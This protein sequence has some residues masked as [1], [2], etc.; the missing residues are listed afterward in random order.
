MLAQTVLVTVCGEGGKVTVDG[1][2]VAVNPGGTML[3]VRE[4]VPV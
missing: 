1:L 2:S 4:I 3:V